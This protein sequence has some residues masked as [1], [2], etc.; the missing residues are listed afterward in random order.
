MWDGWPTYSTGDR[1]SY[2]V[3]CPIR[4]GAD[5]L[6]FPRPVLPQAPRNRNGPVHFNVVEPADTSSSSRISIFKRSEM[7]PTSCASAITLQHVI[8]YCSEGCD[9]SRW[10]TIIRCN[11][12]GTYVQSKRGN[13][14]LT[15]GVSIKTAHFDFSRERNLLREALPTTT[16]P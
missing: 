7:P 3:N 14:S 13:I 10:V 11:F 2:F 5:F 8:Q 16:Q 12:M 6:S 9:V 4:L 1:I 15:E